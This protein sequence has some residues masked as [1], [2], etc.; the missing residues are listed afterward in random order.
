[1]SLLLGLY[2]CGNKMIETDQFCAEKVIEN[3]SLNFSVKICIEL[4]VKGKKA[5]VDTINSTLIKEILGVAFDGTPANAL[6]KYI[7]NEFD[8]YI[9]ELK[10]MPSSMLLWLNSDSISGTVTF[11]NKDFM[12]YQ[13][14]VESYSG[15]AHGLSETYYLV[16]DLKTGKRLTEN[17]IFISGSQKKFS[18]ILTEI[19]SD[20]KLYPENDTYE[21]E[22]LELNGNFSLEQDT[23][24]Y[25]FNQYEIAPYSSGKI[26]V[27]VPYDKIKDII[28]IDLSQ[29]L[30]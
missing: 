22:G 30:K 18:K 14:D 29:L 12:C 26:D 1:M 8:D 24:V 28:K 2:G 13:Y 6:E 9:L 23:L 7:A 27:R 25:T 17:E 10:K 5:V 4:A 15:G 21:L 16:F 19:L 3:D 11:L 20:N